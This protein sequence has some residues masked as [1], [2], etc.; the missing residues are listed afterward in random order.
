MRVSRARTF[1][2]MTCDEGTSPMATFSAHTASPP[3]P[4]RTPAD[5]RASSQHASIAPRTRSAHGP[6]NWAAPRTR[7]HRSTPAPPA[8]EGAS[9]RPRTI[10]YRLPLELLDGL[11]QI[12]AHEFR[13]PIDP[14]Q[15]GRHDVLLCRVNRPSEG[16]HPVRHRP[17]EDGRVSVVLRE[18]RVGTDDA[19]TL[20]G[21]REGLVALYGTDYGLRNATY[22]SRSTDMTRQAASYRNLRVLLAGDAAHVH[23]PMGGQGLNLGVQDAVNLG[24]KLAQAVRGVSPENLLDTYQAER[25]PVAARALRKTLA[26]TALSRGDARMDAVRETLA[27]LLR[28]D[29]PRKQYAAMMSGLDVHYDLGNGHPLLGRRMPDLDLVTADGPRRVFH[30]LHDAR[31]VLLNLGEPG[32]LDVTPWADRVR[33][34]AARYPGEWEF[35]VLGAVTAPIAVL[36][37]PDGH[38][39]WVGEGTDQGLREA[40]T[41]WFGPPRAT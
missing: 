33:R 1:A 12:P 17:L 27:E 18:E 23:S 11:L 29:G 22:L 2:P 32:T 28:M 36:I 14:L 41:R 7:T 40:L 4:S 6:R 24:W 19:P 16:V 34:V 38:V 20:E 5:S 3:P 35:P 26:Q 9:I 10:P 25:H 15:G 21:L 13:V 31:P 39:A 30:L 37:Q 8:Q